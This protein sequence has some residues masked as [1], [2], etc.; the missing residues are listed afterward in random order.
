M[1]VSS[2][3]GAPVALPPPYFRVHD[4]SPDGTHLLGVSWHE[5]E[6]RVVLANYSLK[7]NTLTLLPEFPLHA[8]FVPDGGLAG[9][10]RDNGKLVVG[11]WP[12]GGHG[13][14]TPIT[15]PMADAI[16]GGAVSRQGHLALSR[17]QATT[18][19]VLITAK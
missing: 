16:Y 17:G 12:D 11:V 3:G 2:E 14:F 15:P 10:R 18:D 13:R 8:L 1:S 9:A 19:V 6:R 5:A 7:D 4:I